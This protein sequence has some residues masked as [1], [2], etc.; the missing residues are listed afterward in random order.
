[1]TQLCVWRAT[2]LT[3]ERVRDLRSGAHRAREGV[4]MGVD[5]ALDGVDEEDVGI[6]PPAQQPHDM[7]QVR[8]P[9]D[10]LH[11]GCHAKE[12][13]E[14]LNADAYL[15]G[16]AAPGVALEVAPLHRPEDQPVTNIE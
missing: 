11:S 15:L 10:A 2:V 5:R 9:Q 13:H 7:A 14:C 8:A 4:D 12:D 3:S 1:M 6:A 16:A